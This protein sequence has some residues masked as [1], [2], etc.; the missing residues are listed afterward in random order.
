MP[1]GLRS[2]SPRVP[3]PRGPCN[4]LPGEALRRCQ[5]FDDRD[6][7][8]S[9]DL[10]DVAD[11]LRRLWVVLRQALDGLPDDLEIAVHRLAQQPVALVV[12]D[13]AGVRDLADKGR[14]VPDV[15]K[16]LGRPG[17][18]RRYAVSC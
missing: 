3:A 17:L 16:Q 9:H 14:R 5:H 12:I 10:R 13:R 2:P 7:A 15:L 1:H 18:H 6:V 11:S 8:E 4:A